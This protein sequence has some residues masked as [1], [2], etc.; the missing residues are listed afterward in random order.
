MSAPAL[1]P[2]KGVVPN[3]ENPHNLSQPGLAILQLVLTTVVVG[4]RVYTKMWVVR[5]ML[6]EDCELLF[7]RRWIGVSV[8]SMLTFD[9]DWL[10]VAWICF[11]AFHVNVFMFEA[12][13]LGV[14]Q[15][16][17]TVRRAIEH[18]R[19]CLQ[20]ASPRLLLATLITNTSSSSIYPSPSTP[21]SSSRS[22]YPSSS[23][24]DASSSRTTAHC[25]T[26]P[27]S[28]GSSTAS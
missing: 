9:T 17:L 22:K 3:F 1:A 28:C 4:I 18:A 7:E 15:W 24:S 5:K 23:K 11:A 27:L 25:T 16:D 20:L 13:P 12:L 21:S 10:I 6:A 8:I 2:P 26:G 19:V 14:H